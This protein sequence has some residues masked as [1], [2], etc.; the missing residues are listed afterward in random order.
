MPVQYLKQDLRRDIIREVSNQG[1]LTLKRY[2]RFQK[3]N[4]DQFVGYGRV[5]C[6]QIIYFIIVNLNSLV[7]D[8]W[9][10]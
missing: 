8:I 4:M 10:L 1:E 9:D 5:S 6:L 7:M 3:I 2:S